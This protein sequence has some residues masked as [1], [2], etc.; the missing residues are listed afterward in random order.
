M[1][2]LLLLPLALAACGGSAVEPVTG[3]APSQSGSGSGGGGGGGGSVPPVGPPVVDTTPPSTPTNV[4]ATAAGSTGATL[5]WSASTDN[6]GVTSYVIHRNGASAGTSTTTNFSDVSLSP[7]TTYSFTVAARDA[8]GNTSSQSAAASVTTGPPAAPPPPPPPPLAGTA[9]GNLAASMSAGTWAQLSVSN[10][11]AILGVGDIS[12]TMIHFSNSMPWN[13]FSKVIEIIGSDHGYG[14]TRHVRYDVASNQFVLVSDDAGIGATHGYDHEAVNPFTGDLYTRLYSGFT[15][16]ISSMR[17]VLGGSSFVSIPSVSAADQVAIGTTWWSGNFI[18][19]GNQ[20]SFMIFNSGNALGNANDGQILAYDPVT[21]LWFFNKEGM[22]P[23]YGS[24]STYHS[25][26]EYSPLKNVAVYGGGNVAPSKLWRMSADGSMTPMTDVPA[27]KGVGIQRGLLVNEPVTGNF[28]LLS[29][30][31]L[32]ELNPDGAG[33]WTKLANP[34]SGVGDPNVPTAVIT[35]SISDYGVVA[36][37]TQPSQTGG[38][39][40]LYKRQ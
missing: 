26:M 27:G 8:A 40:Y 30:G 18:G 38:T 6:V 15:G 4:V 32:W 20:G 36:Y 34:P 22:A 37:I 24:G 2:G 23:F 17:K 1:C 3:G 13:P 29:S 25:L 14:R 33:T 12:G 7:S 16:T 19:G 9:L 39:F 31:E 21:N 5:T 10:E 11:D 35:S 28:L